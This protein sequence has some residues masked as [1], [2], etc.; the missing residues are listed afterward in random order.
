MSR[1]FNREA[2]ENE[3]KARETMIGVC[4][5]FDRKAEEQREVGDGALLEFLFVKREEIPEVAVR[6][7]ILQTKFGERL[8]EGAGEAGCLGDWRE[9]G[10][11]F[12]GC[13]GVNDAGGQRF[14]TEAGDGRKRETAHGLR[15]EIG[16]ELGESQRVNAL[17]TGWG[18]ADGEFIGGSSRG[19]DDEDFG[20]LGFL[21][22]ERG[23]ALEK[24]G[25]GAGMKERARGHEQLY[26]VEI[27]ESAALGAG[28]REIRIVAGTSLR[29]L[30]GPVAARIV[31]VNEAGV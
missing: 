27:C 6:G 21:G 13:G 24:C 7:H 31:F 4:G 28:D 19:S 10:Q 8:G 1:G 22:E 16:R 3:G 23:G 25:V 11:T 17:A 9:V 5:F 30:A 29:D 15:C 12:R 14:D 26:W 2:E 18:S 20:V